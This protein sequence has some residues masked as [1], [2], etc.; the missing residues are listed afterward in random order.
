MQEMD[1]AADVAPK[2]FKGTLV[3][4]VIV[5]HSRDHAAPDVPI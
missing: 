2:L 3:L 4:G 5:F 1:R